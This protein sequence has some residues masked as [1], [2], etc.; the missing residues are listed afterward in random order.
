M[1]VYSRRLLDLLSIFFL[2][3][4]T[5]KPLRF[6]GLTGLTSLFVG[7]IYTGY[8]VF[9]RFYMGVPLADRP[10]LLLGLLLIVLGIQLFAIGLVGELIIFTHAREQREYTIDKMVN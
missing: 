9:Q 6:F 2:V 1:G 8:L 5:R 10:A 3:K 7:G 4:F